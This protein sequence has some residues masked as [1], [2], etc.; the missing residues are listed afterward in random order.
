M[1]REFEA[2]AI[3]YPPPP[4]ISRKVFY[5]NGLDLLYFLKYS[6]QVGYG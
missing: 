4:P 2:M 5:L 3:G 1:L 6:I